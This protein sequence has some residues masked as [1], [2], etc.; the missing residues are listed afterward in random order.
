M[1]LSKFDYHLNL[2]YSEI[3]VISEMMQNLHVIGLNLIKMHE[4]ADEGKLF[5]KRCHPDNILTRAYSEI[6]QEYFY[7]RFA[8]FHVSH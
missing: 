1:Y 5:A 4:I 6:N 2:I 3:F 8:G 7:G